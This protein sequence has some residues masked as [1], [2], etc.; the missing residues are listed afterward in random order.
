MATPQEAI[1]QKVEEGILTQ[2][3]TERMIML[4]SRSNPKNLFHE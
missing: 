2:E 3:K 4:P 1:E